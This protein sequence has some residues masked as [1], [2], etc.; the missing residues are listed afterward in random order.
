MNHHNVYAV[1][2]SRRV[3]KDRPHLIER[4]NPN[5][6]SSKPVV[7]VGST[8]LT[9]E[10]RFNNHK[11][12]H[13]GNAFVKQYGLKLLPHLYQH[14]NPTTFHNA[15]EIEKFLAGK[16]RD[17]GYTVLGGNEKTAAE[18]G[19]VGLSRH[20]LQIELSSPKEQSEN[21]NRQINDLRRGSLGDMVRETRIRDILARIETHR[22]PDVDSLP[23][24]LP[25][26]WENR[27]AK[28]INAL[29]SQRRQ[30]LANEKLPGLY[31]A[32]NQAQA[33]AR[34]EGSAYTG[35]NKIW[36]N[37]DHLTDTPWDLDPSQAKQHPFAYST[38]K[39][40]SLIAHEAWHAKNPAIPQVNWG[41]Q[42]LTP[43]VNFGR[44]ETLARWYEG[45]RS[46][47]NMN[48]LSATAR[49]LTN[50]ARYQARRLT[51][52]NYYPGHTL[53]S[54]WD[55]LTDPYLPHGKTLPAV[56]LKPVVTSM[57]KN[58]G[59]GMVAGVPISMG[60]EAA[61]PTAMSTPAQQASHPVTSY[62]NDVAGHWLDSTKAIT[63]GAATGAAIS[64]GSAAIPGAIAGGIGDLAHKSWNAGRDVWDIGKNLAGTMQG[65]ARIKQMQSKLQSPTIN[66]PTN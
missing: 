30:Q 65:N 43:Q 24:D 52:P 51:H 53:D 7:Y 10:Q 31:D 9:P 63:G 17:S 5:R 55:R 35:S 28:L 25:S 29:P 2:L 58:L 12:G 21:I 61:A 1:Q 13:K 33:Q 39:P 20:G 57:G 32:L 60:L 49:G 45:F 26:H 47:K 16:L 15:E 42:N 23:A 44:S 48:P 8:G 38:I 37:K 22:P 11:N 46:E 62:L 36:L 19:P 18:L 40:R 34:L 59:K 41:A 66:K 6:R 50:A 54:A 27:A 64:G 3:L 14:Y 56:D 4:L